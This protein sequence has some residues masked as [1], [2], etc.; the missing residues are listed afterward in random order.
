MHGPP[1]RFYH[2]PDHQSF[3]NF[4]PLWT[5]ILVFF[6]LAEPPVVNLLDGAGSFGY[7]C[8][9]CP[10]YLGHWLRPQQ[11]DHRL[12][13]PPLLPAKVPLPGPGAPSP[14]RD[15]YGNLPG[16]HVFCFWNV[17]DVRMFDDCLPLRVLRWRLGCSFLY[18]LI[19]HRVTL[20]LQNR[21]QVGGREV[22]IPAATWQRPL[23]GRL[24]AAATQLLAGRGSGPWEPVLVFLSQ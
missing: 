14:P 20:Y 1:N 19:S 4:Y 11:T 21:R 13:L 24:A 8:F 5:V 9:W 15:G 17:S 23:G 12:P 3:D 6:S 7:L 2:P 10:L 22:A 18:L 16:S